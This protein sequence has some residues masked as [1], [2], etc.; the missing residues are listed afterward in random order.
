MVGRKPSLVARD[1]DSNNWPV[2]TST[3]FPRNTQS[4]SWLLLK[5]GKCCRLLILARITCSPWSRFV[6]PEKTISG[7]T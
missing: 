5:M 6:V 7:K 4:I 1:V 3:S 2:G